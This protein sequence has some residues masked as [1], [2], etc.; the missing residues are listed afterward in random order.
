MS[1]GYVFLQPGEW[2]RFKGLP[3]RRDVVEGLIHQGVEVMRYG[4]SMVNSASYKWKNMIGSPDRRPDYHGLWYPY[5]TNGWG[6][7]DFLNLCEAMGIVGIPDLNVNQTPQDLADV[8]EYVNGPLDSEWGKRRAID[9]HPAPYLLHYLELGNEERVDRTY[10]EKFNALADAI[11]KKDPGIILIVG[12]FSYSRKIAD[13]DHF[14]G[15]DSRITSMEGHRQI[16]N[17]A[18]EHDREVWFDIHVW[19]ENLPASANLNALPSYLD[20][21]DKVAGRAKHRAVV[22]ELNANSHG[23]KRALANA[24]S[25]NTIRRDNRM[26]IVLSAN[27]LQPDGENDNGWDQGL[28]FLNSSQAWLQPPG[29]VTQMQSQN[30]QPMLVKCELKTAD[31]LHLDATASRSVDGKILVLEVVNPGDTVAADIDLSGFKPVNAVAAVT[32]MAG[33]LGGVNTAAKSDLITAKRSNWLCDFTAGK[34][35]RTFPSHSFTVI[36]FE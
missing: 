1:L 30:F 19:S 26:P 14:S 10:A 22:F 16:L 31:G 34:A 4:G 17:F 33:E 36:R 21:L 2:G 24:I 29:Y 6:V 15:A 5:S 9:G 20:A 7:I 3:V 27:A 13:P 11:W 25:I 8:I 35:A 28:L 23:Q 32:E 12:D 18:R